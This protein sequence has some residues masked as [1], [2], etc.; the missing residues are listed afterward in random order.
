VGLLRLLALWRLFSGARSGGPYGRRYGAP[1]G[2][3]GGRVRVVGCAPGCLLTSLLL[4][5]ALTVLVNVLI[6]LL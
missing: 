4:S 3:G 2:Y 1:R 5:V 6:R